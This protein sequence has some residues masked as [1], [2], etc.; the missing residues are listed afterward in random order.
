MY[1]IVVCSAFCLAWYGAV[2]SQT[3]HSM[4]WDCQTS[5]FL[6]D[7]AFQ[8]H[9]QPLLSHCFRCCH[10]VI[11]SRICSS[12][13]WG[14]WA[15]CRNGFLIPISSSSHVPIPV[16]KLHHVCFHSHGIS[17]GNGE[18]GIPSFSADLRRVWLV[19]EACRL[20]SAS[21]AKL[22]N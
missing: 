1:K 7:H 15:V 2:C 14:T 13:T 22:S 4:R 6:V 18:L 19:A 21:V 10:K 11:S 8:T 9:P 16:L 12:I 17:V 3:S 5:M 20:T